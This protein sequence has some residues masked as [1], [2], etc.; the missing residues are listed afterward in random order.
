[1]E[2]YIAIFIN[3]NLQNEL[4]FL[5][6]KNDIMQKTRE[7]IFSVAC[8]VTYSLLGENVIETEEKQEF[9]PFKVIE[10]GCN[11]ISFIFFQKMCY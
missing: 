5:P 11:S 3:F 6:N 10:K 1:M 2:C 7:D 9:E 8:S 4:I